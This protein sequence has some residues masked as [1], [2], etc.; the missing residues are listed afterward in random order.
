VKIL[1]IHDEKILQE[2]FRE[3]FSEDEVF[4][5]SHGREAIG[6]LK[7]SGQIDVALINVEN[8][9][10]MGGAEIASEIKK[11][12]KNI[13][14]LAISGYPWR[15]PEIVHPEKFQFDNSIESPFILEDIINKVKAFG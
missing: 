3:I 11:I 6:I 13:R 7:D 10:G 4:M 2:M 9:R 5:A 1:V 12:N 8:G 15:A 14:T